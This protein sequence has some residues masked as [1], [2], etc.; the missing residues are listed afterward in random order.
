[1]LYSISYIKPNGT[2][3]LFYE[4]NNCHT[5]LPQKM[6]TQ[7]HPHPIKTTQPNQTKQNKPNNINPEKHAMRRTRTSRHDM[8]ARESRWKLIQEQGGI[9]QVMWYRYTL[10]QGCYT[11]TIW[12]WTCYI[13]RVYATSVLGGGGSWTWLTHI[14]GR[15]TILS[16]NCI[17]VKDIR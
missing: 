3:V 6:K 16:L 1:M 7:K 9:N 13:L 12:C 10:M 15:K 4:G 8:G 14:C 11:G 5:P 2:L 17:F